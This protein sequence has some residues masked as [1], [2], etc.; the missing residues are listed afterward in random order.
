MKKCITTLVTI[1]FFYITTHAQTRF[2]GMTAAGGIHD[3]GVI[4]KIKNDG[5]GFENVYSFDPSTGYNPN[6]NLIMVRKV[7]GGNKHE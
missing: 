5:S 6:G 3:A 4:F 2:W 1:S 7:V